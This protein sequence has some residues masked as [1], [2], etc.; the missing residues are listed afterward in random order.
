[1]SGLRGPYLVGAATMLLAIGALLDSGV[2]EVTF[3]AATVLM[4]AALLLMVGSGERASDGGRLAALVV[5][6]L[7]GSGFALLLALKGR[8]S[9]ASWWFGLPA[10]LATQIAMALLPLVIL[11]VVFA[12]RFDRFRPSRDALEKIQA[13]SDVDS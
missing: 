4:P 8:A 6:V 13:L 1:M 12:R 10:P 3:V 5:V 7:L 2:G 9:T 11:G